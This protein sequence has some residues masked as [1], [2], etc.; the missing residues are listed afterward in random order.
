MSKGYVRNDVEIDKGWSEETL[1]DFLVGLFT[2]KLV[3]NDDVPC[4]Y[5]K[6]KPY[7]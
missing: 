4:R 3:Q 2:D 6:L 5:S 7:Y 1:M